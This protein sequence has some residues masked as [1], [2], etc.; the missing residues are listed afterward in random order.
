[1]LVALLLVVAALLDLVIPHP[2]GVL[3]AEFGSGFAGTII[4]IGAGLL[5]LFKGKIDK[6]VKTALDGMR[7]TLALA[8][9]ALADFA[10]EAGNTQ[11][12]S[13]GILRRLW[14]LV[15]IGMIHK[16]DKG[17]RALR[18]WL[19]H[20][21]GPILRALLKVRNVLLRIYSKWLKP[22]FDT[23]EVIR[24][25]LQLLS[26]LHIDVARKLDQSLAEL[27][28]RLRRIILV[29]LQKLNEV[30]D[31]VNLVIDL[32]GFFQRYTYVRSMVLYERDHWNNWWASVHLR[33]QEKPRSTTTATPARAIADVRGDLF[34]YVVDGNGPD[35]ERID[36]HLDDLWLRLG[37]AS[38]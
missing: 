21:L 13:V 3:R 23:I 32:G 1:M 20:T 27:E 26:F 11:A 9:N 36:E 16:V 18:D 24:H 19:K 14:D 25:V 38:P 7:L 37:R 8:F 5:G 2:A 30:I 31:Q 34:A 6:N 33:E 12:K 17:I 4:T 10:T 35:K 28:A 22:I 15:I 29:P